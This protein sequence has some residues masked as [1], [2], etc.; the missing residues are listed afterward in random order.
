MRKVGVIVNPQS[1]KDI[2]RIVGGG[3][4]ASYQDKVDLTRRILTGLVGGGIQEILLM[5]DPTSLAQRAMSALGGDVTGKARVVATPTYGSVEDTDR[6]VEAMSAEGCGCLITVGGDGTNRRVARLC[7]AIPLLPLP[8]GTNNVFCEPVDGIVAGLAAGAYLKAGDKKSR[9]RWRAKRLV[10]ERNGEPV[11]EALIDVALSDHTET[12]ARAL[13]EAERLKELVLS[14]GL[15]TRIGL[16]AIGGMVEPVGPRDK[17]GL[18]VKLRRNTERGGQVI[19]AGILPGVLATV[20]VSQVHRVKEGE[21]VSL[22]KRAGVL[23]LDGER[24][25][26]IFKGQSWQVRLQADGPWLIDVDRTM[27]EAVKRNWLNGSG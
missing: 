2:R 9:L 10:I 21:A 17:Q 11:D 19:Q 20:R 25:I 8:G 6:V 26:T 3:T 15:P 16:S 1:G 13:W 18:H 5:P 24:E 4:T 27:G 23:A 12:G 7:G 14:Q 22:P